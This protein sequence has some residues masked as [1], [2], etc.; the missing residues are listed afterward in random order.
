MNTVFAGDLRVTVYSNP[1]SDRQRQLAN[2]VN[3][4]R[5]MPVHV[6]ACTSG[7]AGR[8][9][10]D[11]LIHSLAMYTRTGTH[12]TVAC[13][14][15]V[16][17]IPTVS[18]GLWASITIMSPS[19]RKHKRAFTQ[20][21]VMGIPREGNSSSTIVVH[22]YY[23]NDVPPHPGQ[24]WTRFVCVSDTHS[25]TFPLPDGDVLI[26]AGDLCSWGSVP[27]LKVTMDWLVSLPHP[28]KM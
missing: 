28:K 22:D 23:G 24:G 14:A 27:Q 10:L 2:Q 13:T 1:V 19:S 3:T 18:A 15:A 25:K 9:R 17:Y 7:P 11:G 6:A 20:P 26:H 21:S 5:V 12:C 4:C 8:R 16:S